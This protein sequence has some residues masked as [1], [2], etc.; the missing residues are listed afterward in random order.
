[1]SG[2]I[3]VSAERVDAH[4]SFRHMDESVRSPGW[5]EASCDLCDTATTGSEPVVEEWAYEHMETEHPV[6]RAPS[7]RVADTKKSHRARLELEERIEARAYAERRRDT[8]DDYLTEDFKDGVERATR[9]A[10]G[11]LEAF[12]EDEERKKAETK[13]QPLD[14]VDRLAKIYI[15]AWLANSDPRLVNDVTS[16]EHWSDDVKN[17]HR[18]AVRALLEALEED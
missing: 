12:F 6:G 16:F 11:A 1:M 7:E 14:K 10:V 9:I 13:L 18:A 2:D 8:R 17:S 5:Y 4:I 15:A 3:V